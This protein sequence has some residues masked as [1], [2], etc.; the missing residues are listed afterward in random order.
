MV[1]WLFFENLREAHKSSVII[2]TMKTYL[3][4]LIGVLIGIMILTAGCQLNP[5]AT[6]TLPATD[7]T[8]TALASQ[9]LAV[10]ATITP[11]PLPMALTV[12]NEGVPLVEYQASLKQLKDSA[13]ELGKTLTD[14]EM[15]QMVLDD[16]IDQTLLAE[17][18]TKNGFELDKAALDTHLSELTTQLGG[19]SQLNDWMG[20][21]GYDLPALQLALA[22][23]IR[24]AWQ[25]DQIIASVPEAVEQVKA[26]QIIVRTQSTADELYRRLQNGEDFATLASNYDP[27]TAG[28]LGWFPRGYLTVPA[29]DEAVFALQTGEYTPVIETELGFVILQVEERADEQPLSPDARLV[30]QQNAID[31]WL[32][33]ERENSQIQILVP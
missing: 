30:L 5:A 28:E 2:R 16:L 27:I 31:D 9:E 23:S 10:T 3:Q 18:A 29:L 7:S 1:I 13:N 32:T 17:A 33:G 26:R 25:R 11:T 24:A 21:M 4:K 15:P 6:G 14:D 8:Q 22:R 19:E 12:N 20:K